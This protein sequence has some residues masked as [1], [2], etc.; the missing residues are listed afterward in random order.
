[1]QGERETPFPHARQPGGE[2]NPLPPRT[3]AIQAV[4]RGREGAL[5][6]E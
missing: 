3:S 5:G 4:E 1:M 6:G 2:G